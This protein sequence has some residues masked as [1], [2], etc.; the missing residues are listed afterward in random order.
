MVYDVREQHTDNHARSAIGGG[1]GGQRYLVEFIMVKKMIKPRLAGFTL[2]ETM[3]VVAILGIIVMTVP[4]MIT[5][6]T[7]FAR[8]STARIETQRVARDA[9]G[10]LNQDLRQATATSIEISQETGQ[11]P[12]SSITFAT[13]DGRTLKYYQS[14]KN[15]MFVRGTSTATVAQGLRYIAF[16][17]PRTDDATIISVSITTEKETYEGGTKALQMAIEKVRIMN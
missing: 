13:S 14:N 6:V 10:R 16:T 2:L 5:N 9:L 8:L 4:Q 11:P 3:I 17:Y 15:L 7:K 12:C 1:D